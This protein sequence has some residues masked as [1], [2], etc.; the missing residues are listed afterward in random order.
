MNP[1]TGYAW[2]WALAASAVATGLCFLLDG[3][4]SVAGLA[5][6]YLVATVLCALLFDRG[7]ALLASLAC[8]SALNSFFLPPRSN[9]EVEGGE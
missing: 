2:F 5:M 8:V 6:V 7:P 1:R 9:F 4:M 3:F